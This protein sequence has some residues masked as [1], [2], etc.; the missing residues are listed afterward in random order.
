MKTFR[1]GN[2]LVS[3]GITGKKREL[4]VLLFLLVGILPTMSKA[5]I[6]LGQYARK[7]TNVKAFFALRSSQEGPGADWHSNTY[8]D[9]TWETVAMPISRGADL[10]YYNTEWT[11]NYSSY[12][13]RYH[14]N[15]N[16]VDTGADYYYYTYHDDESTAYINGVQ[17]YNNGGV[18]SGTVTKLSA[19]AV[20]ALKK[21]DNVIAVYV[22]DSGG[23]GMYI[24]F[25]LY[26]FS[27]IEQRIKD[28]SPLS[29]TLINDPNYP[30]IVD[31][32]DPQGV[33]NGNRGT[34]NTTSDLTMTYTSTKQTELAFDWK[35]YDRNS[36]YL[37]II[38]DGEEK[39]TVRHNSNWTEKRY[40]LAAGSHTIQFRDTVGNYNSMDNWTCIKNVRVTEIQ[41]LK[42]VLL[43]SR[44]KSLTFVN[45][46]EH[47][48]I[49]AGKNAQNTTS[50]L[51]NTGSK[52]YT[53]VKVTKTSRLNFQRLI[54]G[55]SNYESNYNLSFMV[56]GNQFL[57]EWGVDPFA[58]FKTV[59][60]PGTYTLE[61]KDTTLN[62]TQTH[63]S[64]I[65]N[66]ELYD[67]WITCELAKAGTL[68]VEALYQVDVLNDVE[69]LKVV[70]P[71]NTADWTTIKNMGNLAAL[72]LSEAQ[73]D[74]L[75]SY[76]FDGKSL[77]ASVIL[78]DGLQTI[79]EYAFR[80]TSL[81]RI[82]IPQTVTS[83]ER[84]AFA[85]TPIYLLTIPKSAQLQT[86]KN[87]AF[88]DCTLLK[89]VTIGSSSHLKTIE[90]Y[91]F[92]N[93]NTLE[94]FTM[95][96][97]VTSLGRGAFVYCRKMNTVWISNGLK[98]LPIDAFSENN[99]LENIHFPTNL[100]GIAQ[101]CFYNSNSLRHIELPAS[102][103]TIGH[104]AFYH[105]GI[106]SL[107]LPL[108]MDYL[109]HYAFQGCPNLTYVELPSYVQRR[110]F[111][112]EG[113]NIYSGMRS[114]F[115][116]CPNLKKIVSRSATPPAIVEDPFGNCGDKSLITLVVPSFAVVNYKLD[117]YWYQ[118]GSII[119]GDD[120][121][122]WKL[123]GDLSLTNNRRMTGTPNVD[124]YFDGKL[125]VGGSAPMAMG[126][127]NWFVNESNPGTLFNTCTAMTATAVNTYF[128][129]NRNTWYFFTPV[130]D[131]TLS[132]VKV[133][134]DAS[135]VFRYY[136]S[137]NRAANGTGASWKDVETT[138]LKAGQ[139]Y[140]FHCSADAVVTLPAPS[141]AQ[142]AKMFVTNDVTKTLTAYTAESTANKNWNYVGNPYPSYY[143]IYYMD[144]TA[145][146]TVWTGSTY[147]AYSIAD[148]DFVLRPMQSFFVQKPD[149][150]DK[151][152]FHQEGR[153]LTSA[154]ERAS[155]AKGYRMSGA[156]SRFLFDIQVEQDG[157]T[158]ETRVV[159]NEKSSVTYEL[160][161]DASKFMSFAPEV[162]QV[163]TIDS[164]GVSYAI[165]ER[166]LGNGHV[167]LAYST[168]QA[169]MVSIIARRADGDLFLHDHQLNKV[170]RLNEEGYEFYTEA[171]NGANQSRFT[172]EFSV[173]DDADGL[174]TVEQA[175]K[176]TVRG[177]GSMLLV[178]AA[179]GEAI[180][181]CRLDGSMVFQGHATGKQQSLSLPSGAYIVKVGRSTF[182]TM[183]Y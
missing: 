54:T 132:K 30:W 148:D 146:I 157:L 138:T 63:T 19:E 85:G 89:T 23:G 139:G 170:V 6:P 176:A 69:M 31:T 38:I 149:A 107:L 123:T 163:F 1:N 142:R 125:M 162:P 39:E 45:D 114:N 175:P 7:A 32:G 130:Y 46:P 117:T 181:V 119:E 168:S 3:H 22:S 52:F 60:E 9:S 102:L 169:G 120:A 145:P 108:N 118:F 83:I 135:Y 5:I 43:T 77:L 56:N 92:Y 98:I 172:L 179:P 58:D 150:V 167:T 122:Y 27:S 173:N 10:F 160:G 55:S 12:W 128:S 86:I 124:L 106:D 84:Y 48:W 136:D 90:E 80:G 104:R 64:R 49:Q 81:R 174:Q 34:G 178:N 147:R 11:T 164:E 73:F 65:R 96:N 71:M 177:V 131:V 28:N 127:F 29:Y 171:T 101:T 103:K 50:G 156:S 99:A 21:G 40:Y 25:G 72:D 166:P 33:I 79:G 133:S 20:A 62:T 91:A 110:D 42:N 183:L 78:P 182:K 105:C 17:I 76:A 155:Y 151:I 100:E 66:V 35:S 15:L 154:V 67:N 115:N 93:C 111:S 144:F 152:I 47:P 44:S 112:Y 16:S 14:F 57:K 24:D 129:A 94:S 61:W 75:P 113:G 159:V 116:D 121:N 82:R 51:P 8:D 109:S 137:S 4:A 74:V 158:D 180:T 41:P 68:G 2:A 95:P 126:T 141:A 59:L 70:G 88:R 165:N 13:V 26:A 143:D 161:H 97:T 87:N 140:I 134:N 18:G 53:T 36:H 153:Q 37:K